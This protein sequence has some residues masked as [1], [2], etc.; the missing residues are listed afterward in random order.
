MRQPAPEDGILRVA[1]VRPLQAAERAGM[2]LQAS[3]FG[4]EGIARVVRQCSAG[5]SQQRRRSG[6]ASAARTGFEPAAA[7]VAFAADYDCPGA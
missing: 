3:E 2:A 4:F 6:A 1:A 7:G 5:L